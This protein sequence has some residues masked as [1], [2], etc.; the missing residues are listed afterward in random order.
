[1]LGAPFEQAFYDFV[2]LIALINPISAAA[3]FATLTEGRSPQ[4][5][6]QIAAR[7]AIVAGITLIAFAFAGEALL[8]A[9]GVEIGAFKIAGGLL[10][11]KVGFDMVF[12]ERTQRQTVDAAKACAGPTNDPSVFPLAIPIIT[13]PG[14]LTASV[15]L[16]NPSPNHWLDGVT[17]VMVAVVV[18]GISYAFMRAAEVLMKWLGQTGIDAISRVVGIVVA[19]IAVQ[20]IVNGISSLT[21]LKI[22]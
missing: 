8:G 9:L 5:Q 16:V 20:L 17:F 10:L 2:T 4:E 6:A 15:A 14:A 7:A 12:A 19:A 21:N 22:H 18:I 11:L 3:A 1:M 13:G